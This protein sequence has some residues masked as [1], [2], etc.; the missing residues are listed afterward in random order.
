MIPPTTARGVHGRGGIA[1]LTPSYRRD[2]ERC[3]LLCE[4]VDRHVR[5]R[6]LHYLV[7]HDEDLPSFAHLAGPGR[8]VLPT[9]RFVPRALRPIPLLRWRGRRY[10]WVPGG[11]PV[12]GWHVQQIVKIQAAVTLP[13]DR[14]CIVDSDNVFFRDVSLRGLEAPAPVP[15]LAQAAAI[16]RAKP[17]HV[18]WCEAA[19]RLLGLPAPDLPAD[20]YIDQIIVWDRATVSAML[21][22]VEAVTGRDWVGAL[23]RE[24]QFSEYMIYGAFVA[25][26]G[27]PTAH[28]PTADGFCHAHWVADGLDRDGVLAMLEGTPAGRVALC[29][30]SFGD[31]PPAAIAWATARFRASRATA[32]AADATV[33]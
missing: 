19:A 21:A 23:C 13:A 27:A 15:L 1:L 12:S 7:I 10:W 11:K 24:R 3:E 32:A 5:D 26:H 9:S 6:G 22:R 17:R 30:Q 28:R 16:T 2:L 4:S 31:T 8:V 33:R 25:N 29:V 14:L 20:D 18:A